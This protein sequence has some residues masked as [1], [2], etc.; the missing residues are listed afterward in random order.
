M[1]ISVLSVQVL[2][3]DWLRFLIIDLKFG[4]FQVL[5]VVLST[6]KVKIATALLVEHKV[7]HSLW[8]SHFE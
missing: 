2:S 1:D 7:W 6:F 8:L 3:F 4:F 5:M